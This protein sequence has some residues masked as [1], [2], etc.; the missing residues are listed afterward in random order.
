MDLEVCGCIRR[1]VGASLG[2][3]ADVD[4]VLSCSVGSPSI[5]VGV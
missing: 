1:G 5:A 4:T 2:V 3:E